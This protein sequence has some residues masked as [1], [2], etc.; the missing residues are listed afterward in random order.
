MAQKYPEGVTEEW[1]AEQ[2]VFALKK[3]HEVD[4]HFVPIDEHFIEAY[5]SGQWL[6]ERLL[7]LGCERTVASDITGAHGQVACHLPAWDA[8]SEGV[9]ELGGA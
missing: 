1:V 3:A 5:I 8:A 7:A 9:E 2:R 4:D 6:W